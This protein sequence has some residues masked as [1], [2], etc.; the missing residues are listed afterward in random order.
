MTN[1]YDNFRLNVILDRIKDK[2]ILTKT[3]DVIAAC[4]KM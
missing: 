4:V 1:K 2:N 3:A